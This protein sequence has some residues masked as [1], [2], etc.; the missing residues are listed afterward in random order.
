MLYCEMGKTG[1]KLLFWATGA[2]ASEKGR[3]I[4]E[5]RTERQV[6]SAID[7]ESTTWIRVHIQQWG[8]RGRLG[9][10]L[11]KGYRDRVNVATKLPFPGSLNWRH[12]EAPGYPVEEAPNR[13]HRLLPGSC[14]IKHGE[15][16]AA[17]AARDRPI[18]ENARQA[19][20]IVG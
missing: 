5:E 11:A 15:L 13:P 19:G 14:A 9:K 10:I 12:G 2:C 4:D 1:E 7:R 6:I 3:G 16:A 8:K 17:E 18:F 20:K